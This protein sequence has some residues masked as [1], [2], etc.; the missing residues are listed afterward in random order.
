MSKKTPGTYR[1]RRSYMMPPIPLGSNPGIHS[2]NLRKKTSMPK[3]L[4]EKNGRITSQEEETSLRTQ[5]NAYPASLQTAENNGWRQIE[6][7]Q[8]T[9]E[10]RQINTDGDRS[11]PPCAQNVTKPPGHRPSGP[12]LPSH[13][14]GGR[15]RNSPSV[16]RGVP[17]LAR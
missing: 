11:T 12:S 13:S 14:A 5:P 6:L 2:T 15:I 3:R 1:S 7:G 17:Q 16:G 8:D 10:Q 9:A 4:G